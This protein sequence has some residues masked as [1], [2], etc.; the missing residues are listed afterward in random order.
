MYLKIDNDLVRKNIEIFK[1]ILKRA[2]QTHEETKN[3]KTTQQ[4][5]AFIHRG[6]G[7][8]RFSDIN[9]ESLDDKEWTLVSFH[10]SL[11]KELDESFSI[12]V[13][14]IDEQQFS[15]EGFNPKAVSALKETL[16]TIQFISRFLPKL[17]NL[18]AEIGRAHV[19]T[20]VTL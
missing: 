17:K 4:F 6:C 3:E 20:P 11:P 10:F 13:T 14:D 12:N 8:I 16:K 5:K 15:W 1:I 9:P 2:I 18:T 19:W 7:E